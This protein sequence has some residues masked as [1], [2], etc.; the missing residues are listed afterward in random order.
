MLLCMQ[1]RGAH[2]AWLLWLLGLQLLLAPLLLLPVVQ[3]PLLL[4]CTS[5]LHKVRHWQKARTETRNAS[6]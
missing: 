2:N 6:K 3:L 5:V 1:R 4:P